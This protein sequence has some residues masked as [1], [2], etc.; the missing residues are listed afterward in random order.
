MATMSNYFVDSKKLVADN[1]SIIKGQK[2]RFTILSDILVRMEYSPNGVFEDRAT[3]QVV[4]RKFDTINY[5]VVETENL[6]QI[7]TIYFTLTYD[8]EKPFTGMNLKV[9]LNESNKEW[10]YQN[11]EVRNFGSINYSLDNYQGSSL[12]GKGLYSSDGFSAIDDSNSLVLSDNDEFI[13][14][15]N[16]IKIK[17]NTKTKIDLEEISKSNN[18]KGLFVKEILDE[19][20]ENNYNKKIL[21]NAL[22]I[23]LEILNNS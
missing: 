21:E 6:I 7:K 5:N 12:L 23:G 2:Y 20:K 1:S 11:K 22:E 3:E 14:R 15:E 16:I 19:L 17:N 18:L 13:L 9:L 4:C 10:T 8:K